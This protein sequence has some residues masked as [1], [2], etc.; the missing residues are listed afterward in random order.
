[1]VA[2]LVTLKLVP[3]ESR[4]DIAAFHLASEIITWSLSFKP[5]LRYC[6]A[7]SESISGVPNRQAISIVLNFLL[8]IISF[9]SPLPLRNAERSGRQPDRQRSVHPYQK[10]ILAAHRHGTSNGGTDASR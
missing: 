4:L 8:Q 2:S 10:G 5:A 6:S 1:M 9:H 7:L 3:P